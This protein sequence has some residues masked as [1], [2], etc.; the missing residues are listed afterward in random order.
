MIKLPDLEAWA[1]FAKVVEMGSFAKAA[2]ELGLSQATVSKA[3]TRLESRVKTTLL[4]RT[5]RKMSLTESGRGALE[6]AARI[7]DEGEAVE[8]EVAAQSANPHGLI[9]LAAPMSFGISHLAPLLPDFMASYPDIALEVDFGDEII[10]VIEHRI[11]IALRISSLADSTL[12]ARRMC[13]VRLLLVGSP[14]YL[15]R[16]GRP[17]HPRELSGHRAFFYTNSHLGDAWRFEHR[18]LGA[19]AISVPAPL[20]VNNAEA[21][22]PVLL[23]GQGLALQ[24]EFICWA[25]L[26]SGRLEQVLP[27]W[28]SPPIALHIVTPPHRA[29]PMRVQLLIDYLA[30]CFANAPWAQKTPVGKRRAR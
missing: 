9:R 21:L 7:L 20:R 4:H 1:I 23:A 22:M 13:A 19:F 18:R 2:D 30:H 14:E 5:S 8:L 10:D 27:E 11:D 17:E 6:R 28:V 15:D 26:Q 29:R 3:I 12:L 25:E 16:H 24:P